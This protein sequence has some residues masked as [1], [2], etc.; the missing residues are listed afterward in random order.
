[1]AQIETA[2]HIMLANGEALNGSNR[3]IVIKRMSD[4]CGNEYWD[5]GFT[6]TAQQQMVHI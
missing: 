1:M 2:L 4:F 6:I 5:I 3:C